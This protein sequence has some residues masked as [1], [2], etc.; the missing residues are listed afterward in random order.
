MRKLFVI[1]FSLSLVL[2]LPV[3]F[4]MKRADRVEPEKQECV[5]LE[6]PDHAEPQ[7][8]VVIEQQDADY[9]DG[10]ERMMRYVNSIGSRVDVPGDSK[11]FIMGK[12][13]AQGDLYGLKERLNKE[14]KN[15]NV[16]LLRFDQRDS[17]ATLD[18]ANITFE[19]VEDICGD[20][21]DMHLVP[22]ENLDFEYILS[23]LESYNYA[24]MP[25][26]VPGN[27]SLKAGAEFKFNFA[28]KEYRMY[29][30]LDDERYDVFMECGDVTNLLL[31][32]ELDWGVFLEIGFIGD[33]DSDGKPDVIF[34]IYS[35]DG[36]MDTILFISTG[37]PQRLL[38]PV[39]R[40]RYFVGC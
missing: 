8:P 9:A 1:L 6:E 15:K 23:G 24:A 11:A 18:A 3:V 21:G 2:L 5:K 38:R 30:E 16:Y 31:R 14:A 10:E 22:C 27:Y 19:V 17:V 7:E 25:C 13:I 12:F 20:E 36:D 4:Y 28:G 32:L 26:L 29:S 34:S 40:S 37:D 35:G 39:A 33:L